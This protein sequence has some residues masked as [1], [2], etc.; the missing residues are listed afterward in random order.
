[1]FIMLNL[2]ISST[3]QM[4]QGVTSSKFILGTN[5]KQDLIVKNKIQ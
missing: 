1:M 3:Y 2:R 5:N 4:I